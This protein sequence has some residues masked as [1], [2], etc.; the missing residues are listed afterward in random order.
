MVA[1][2]Q[3]PGEY[4]QKLGGGSGRRKLMRPRRQFPGSFQRSSVQ[5]PCDQPMIVDYRIPGWDDGGE[6]N[7]IRG[8]RG[9]RTDGPADDPNRIILLQRQIVCVDES[10][11]FGPMR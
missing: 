11:S 9:I 8:A 6:V 10:L 3:R 5:S 1:H 4:D 7:G 2:L